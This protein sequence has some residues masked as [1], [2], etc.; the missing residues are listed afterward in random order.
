MKLIRVT[1]TG[2]D[3]STD[4]ER[5]VKLAQVFPFVEFA[6]LASPARAGEDNR[7]PA[8][9]IINTSTQYLWERKIA[10]AVHVCG[11]YSRKPQTFFEQTQAKFGRLQWNVAPSHLKGKS[12]EEMILNQKGHGTVILQVRDDESIELLQRVRDGGVRVQPLFDA[13][14]GRGVKMERVERPLDDPATGLWTGYAGGISPETV[15]DVLRTLDSILMQDQPIW[16]DMETGV[17][18]DTDWL[19]LDK[20]QEVLCRVFT[21]MREQE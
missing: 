20:V 9:T 13:S 2:I 4:M 16:I 7:Y 1:I 17:R 5:L 11:R 6:F 19:D 14:G 8:M 3:C 15:T 18:S 10:T 21:F 12:I